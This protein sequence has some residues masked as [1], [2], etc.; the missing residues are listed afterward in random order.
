MKGPSTDR[1]SFEKYDIS[2]LNAA[3]L[4]GFD[5]HYHTRYSDSFTSIHG[6]LDLAKKK[7]INLAITD[8]NLIGGVLEAYEIRKEDDPIVVPGIEI[9]SGDGPHIL[10]YFH[11]AGELQDYWENVLRSHIPHCPWLGINRGTEWILNS[12]EGRDCVVSAA[13]PMGYLGTIK[14]VERG[15]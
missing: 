15:V 1:V 12:L 8:H 2:K 10:V 14:G 4:T 5:M 11:T 3:G 13:H 9:S 7:G 6:A